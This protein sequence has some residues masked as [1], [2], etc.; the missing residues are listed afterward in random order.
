MA[1]GGLCGRCGGRKR[2]Q[3]ARA[4]QPVATCA[5]CGEPVCERHVRWDVRAEEDVCYAC[6]AKY[7]LAVIGR[8]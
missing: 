1:R 6:A 5:R 2:G 3:A 8:A 7:G 4:A